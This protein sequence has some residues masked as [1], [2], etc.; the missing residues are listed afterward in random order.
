MNSLKT[1]AA[2]VCSLLMTLDSSAEARSLS[3]TTPTL[4]K[5]L[6][7]PS[8]PL[9]TTASRPVA[10]TAVAESLPTPAVAAQPSTGTPACEPRPAANWRPGNCDGARY[11]DRVGQYVD[12]MDITDWEPRSPARPRQTLV[13]HGR[14]LPESPWDLEVWLGDERLIVTSAGPTRFEAALPAE[15]T[16]GPQRLAVRR[17]SDGE[18]A[19]L[20]ED[21]EVDA[22]VA[23][24]HFDLRDEP[25]PWVNGYL[26]S[27]VSGHM[28]EESLMSEAEFEQLDE[29]ERHGR[30]VERFKERFSELGMERFDFVDVSIAQVDTQAVVMSN[31]SLV[32]LAFRGTENPLIEA[33]NGV[34]DLISDITIALSAVPAEW[35]PAWADPDRPIAVH[36]GF[37]L[38]LDLVYE[39]IRDLVLDHIGTQDKAL[40]VTGH[41]LGGALAS[42]TAYRL[43][44]VDDI[45]VRG[46]H[47]FGS[48][49]VGNLYW[50]YAHAGVGYTAMRWAHIGDPVPLIPSDRTADVQAWLD[51][52]TD[53][54]LD[55]V[56]YGDVLSYRHVGVSHI[57]GATNGEVPVGVEPYWPLFTLDALDGIQTQHGLYA[58]RLREILDARLDFGVLALM[59]E[60]PGPGFRTCEEAL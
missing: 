8:I 21:Y 16:E 26:L 30:F 56:A 19:I 33:V 29:R 35:E 1:T 28:Y 57:L 51:P 54:D 45:D 4:S 36:M 59:P 18:W 15:P 42:L 38:A 44:H 10:R 17:V 13:L 6:A 50:H 5:A 43:E 14:Y 37:K 24:D 53:P 31:D 12:L 52:F 32:I 27:V 11:G 60:P 9:R 25:E 49:R 3:M 40:W 47:T 41:S 20:S 58:C 2:L 39:Q 46:I 23:F 7:K 48:P 22:P 34:Q 55:K